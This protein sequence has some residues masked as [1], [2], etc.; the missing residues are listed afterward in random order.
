[1]TEEGPQWTEWAWRWGGGENLPHQTVPSPV[2]DT[3]PCYSYFLAACC[4]AP[5]STLS[6]KIN[7]LLL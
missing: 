4:N 5:R 3:T 1:M 6:L 7:D 2:G